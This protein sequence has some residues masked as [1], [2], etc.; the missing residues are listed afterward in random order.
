MNTQSRSEFTANW[1]RQAG[2]ADQYDPAARD[3]VWS[4]MLESDPV[5]A[6]WATGV[7]RAPSTTVWGWNSDAVKRLRVPT[8]LVA[9]VHDKQV[10]PDRVRELYDDIGSSQK[11]LVD[12]ACS[13]HNAMWERN[14]RLLF[15]ASLE[16]IAR[17]TVNGQ[18]TG[19]VR[20]GY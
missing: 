3:A 19:T 8:L 2:C 16:W 18:N 4:A 11:L 5:G 20:L 7:R 1:E 10:L 17:G 15:D 9:G 13:S 14:A 6:T 12:L